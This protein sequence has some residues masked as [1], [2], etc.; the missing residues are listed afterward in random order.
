MDAPEI[1]PLVFY[2][3]NALRVGAYL[4]QIIRVANDTEGAKAISYTTWSVWIGANGSTA[5]Y[6]LVISPS[7]ALFL[8]NLANALGC[9]S[10]VILTMWKRRQ[11]TAMGVA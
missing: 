7:L 11:L 1:T 2:L 4:P 9:T 10:V 5:A 3:F 8:V 6:A